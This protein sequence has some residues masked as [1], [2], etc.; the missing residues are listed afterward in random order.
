M[1]GVSETDLPGVGVRYDL[2]TRGGRVV[3]V[4]AHQTGRR[5]L[6]VYEQR[7]PEAAAASVELTGDEARTL[8]ELLGGS[9]MLERLDAL[10][11]RVED[12]EIAWVRIEEDSTVAG[13]TL[14]EAAL[15]SRTG[16]GVVALVGESGSVPVPGGTEVLRAGE[17]AVVVGTPDAVAAASELLAP[18]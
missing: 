12:L 10:T 13:E 15:R 4:V 16:A 3:G 17:M 8:G 7:D 5:D 11:H 9:P 6:V 18:D 14:A 2:P 1:E